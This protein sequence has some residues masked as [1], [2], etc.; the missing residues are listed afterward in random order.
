MDNAILHYYKQNR[1]HQ[2]DTYGLSTVVDGFPREHTGGGAAADFHAVA[3]YRSAKR[4]LAFRERMS[5][6]AAA[7]KK[8]SA[9]AKRG[10]KKRRQH[11]Q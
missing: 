2:R 5:T 8:R 4:H 7:R 10:W 9:A 11:E 6:E 1:A 3:A